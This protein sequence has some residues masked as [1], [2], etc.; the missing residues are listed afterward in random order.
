[1]KVF[2]DHME[3][4]N[5]VTLP[6]GY[7]SIVVLLKSHM[8]KLCNSYLAGVFFRTSFVETLG[9]GYEKNRTSM[10]DAN[11]QMPTFEYKLTR[12]CHKMR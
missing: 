9:R 5:D 8:S 12:E 3:L 4:W 6:V 10:L 2:D 1:M 7:D 11:L